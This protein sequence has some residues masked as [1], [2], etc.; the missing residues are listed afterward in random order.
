MASQ[1]EQMLTEEFSTQTIA[2]RGQ[3]FYAS[4][5]HVPLPPGDWNGLQDQ[6]WKRHQIEVPII[7]FG[8]RWFIRVSCHLYNNSRQLRTLRSALRHLMV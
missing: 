2:D 3:G 1:I 8:D 6:L 4:M 7:F 5:A